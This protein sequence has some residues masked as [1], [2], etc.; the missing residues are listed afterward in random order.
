M[1]WTVDVPRIIYRH[2]TDLLVYYPI[3]EKVRRKRHRE[4]TV[5]PPLV[6]R[7]SVGQ[8]T[9]RRTPVE[10]G[11]RTEEERRRGR[12]CPDPPSYL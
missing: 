2:L 8:G 12:V 4:R 1:S 5:P 9:T 3:P 6:S 10:D 7:V 11:T